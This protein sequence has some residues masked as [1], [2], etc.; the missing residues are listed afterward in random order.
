MSQRPM[1]TIV[2]PAYNEEALI[3]HSLERVCGYLESIEDRY[4]WEV[5]VIDDGSDDRT[6]QIIEEFAREESRVRALRHKTNFSLG[7]A[8]RYAFNNARGD[9][10]VTL[11]SDLTYAPEHIE[12]L[13]DAIVESGAK[14]VVAS[15]YADGGT[16]TAV[17]RFREALSRIANRLLGVSAKGRLTTLTGIV[18]AYDRQF[19]DSLNLKAWDFEINTEIIYK[20]QVLR[21][22]IIEIPAHLDWSAVNDL[23]ERRK[24][25][26]RIGRSILAQ[27]FS[28][29]LFRPFVFFIGPGLTVL[30]LSVFTLSWSLY[31]TIVAWS[32]ENVELF[33]DAVGVAFSVSPHSFIVG[34][35]SLLVGIQLVSLGILS[36]QNKRYFE[37]MFHLGTTVYREQLGLG[38]SR[39]PVPGEDRG[40][41]SIDPEYREA[42]YG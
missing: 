4:T 17:P 35:I 21:A 29:F 38:P 32:S 28:S 12:R 23:G 27:A 26:I 18:R 30:V 2:L 15:P 37:E 16:V 25:S 10:V 8:F 33:S 9:Y 41:R 6:G 19:L 20:A 22:L 1:A 11:D 36:A 31:H 5:I 42:D 14:I 24:S 7:Q 40:I 3:H 34:G 13:L 39:V